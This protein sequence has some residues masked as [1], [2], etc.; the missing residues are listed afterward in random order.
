MCEPRESAAV[1]MGVSMMRSAPPTVV[2][3]LGLRDS[4][5]GC[6]VDS[7]PMELDILRV[8]FSDGAE[9]AAQRVKSRVP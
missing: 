5:E 2:G 9:Y 7:F 8:E 6:G 4:G 3:S 1:A